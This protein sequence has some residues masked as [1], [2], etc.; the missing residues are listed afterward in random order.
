MKKQFE[1]LVTSSAENDLKEIISYIAEQDPGV[2]IKILEKLEKRIETL[3]TLPERGR[4]V[5]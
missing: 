3:K 5:P 1:V 2:A 4:V